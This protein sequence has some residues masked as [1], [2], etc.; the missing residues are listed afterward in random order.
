MKPNT[1]QMLLNVTYHGKE[2]VN[3]FNQNVPYRT[4]MLHKTSKLSLK[5]SL[6]T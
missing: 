1:K 4:I 2:V 5:N 6:L 3:V